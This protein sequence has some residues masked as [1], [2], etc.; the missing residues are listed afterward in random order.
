[1]TRCLLA[2]AAMAL[3]LVWTLSGCPG[4]DPPTDAALPAPR[5]LS[6]EVPSPAL[7]GSYLRVTGVDLDR[8][9]ADPTLSGLEGSSPIFTLSEAAGSGDDDALVFRLS[10]TAVDAL[11]EGS[12]TLDVVVEGRGLASDRYTLSLDITNDLPLALDEG[13]DGTAHRNDVVVLDG[14][15]FVGGEEGTLVLHVEGDFARDGGGTSTVDALLPV[16][17]VEIDDRTRGVVVLST[18]LGGVFPGALSGTARLERTLAGGATAMTASQSISLVFQPPELY[19]FDGAMASVGRLVTVRGAGFLGG[20]DRPSETTL[21][22]IAGTFTPSGGTARP[23]DGE[24][25]P[26]FVS[27][28]EVRVLIETEVQESVVVARLFGAQRGTF[29]GSATPITISGRD[30]VAGAS[31]PLRLVLGPPVQV[32]YLRFLP[33]YY[34]SLARFGLASAEDEIA[35]GI[36]RRMEEIYEGVN[37]DVRLEE[38]TDFDGTATTVI[39][40]GGPDPNGNG[41][42]G[43]DNSPGKD[44]GNVRMFDAIGGTNAE[45]QA[46]GFPGFGGV[47]VQSMLWWSEHPDLPGDRPPSS[48]DPEP[49]FDEIFDPVRERPAS[50]AEI[51]GAGS[52]QR[53]EEIDRAIAALSSIIGETTAHEL[54]HSLGMA[55]PY[56]PVTAF[57]RDDDGDGCVMDRGGDRP[58]AERAQQGSAARSVFCDDEPDYLRSILAE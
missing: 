57:H 6:I 10:R 54:G 14:D 55:Q 22:R 19:S 40:I 39:E 16:S 34:D 7:P 43:Y 48:P 1:M 47:F 50:R 3:A 25:V 42:F 46:D 17:L 28:S 52:A 32:V 15:G 33:G 45:T 8:L 56:G 53:T 5:I 37:V 38:P 49:L 20:A 27:G 2:R 29:E 18:D 26:R 35:E 51:D 41:L 31:A 13:L 12:H 23:L 4:G 36:V 30:E 44:V 11:G 24:L 58:L 21:L 9:G